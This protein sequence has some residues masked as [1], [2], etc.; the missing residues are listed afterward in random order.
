MESS[1]QRV[2]EYV[3]AQ[4]DVIRQGDRLGD[5]APDAVHRARVACR[6]LRS[7]LATFDALW[8]RRHRRLRRDLRWWGGLL[9]LPRDLE[10]TRERLLG[11][12]EAHEL[13]GS[14]EVAARIRRRLDQERADALAG[15][16]AAVGS[17]RFEALQAQVEALRTRPGW[18]PLAQVPAPLV[19]PVLVARPA[20]AAGRLRA[21]LPEGPG[22]AEVVHRIR[23]RAKAARYGYEAAGETEP[24]TAWK[25]V[26]ETLGGTQDAVVAQGW[27]TRLQE[28]ARRAGEPLSGY[29]WLL[30]EVRRRGAEDERTGLM[31][32]DAALAQ[33]KCRP[34]YP[35]GRV[36]P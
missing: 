4:A 8:G 1:A 6:R 20:R 12:V 18:R 17:E 35:D 24:A 28:E 3:E 21:D 31:W 26:T 5:D 11:L 7:S 2:G 22:R 9:G 14:A 30:A 19:L 23:K 16:R 27:L 29:R 13:E 34:L 36:A 33:A 10:V 15:V 25:R 32:L